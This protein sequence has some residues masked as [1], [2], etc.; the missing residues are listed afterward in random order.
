[1]AGI[2]L[3]DKPLAKRAGDVETAYPI[4]SM[5]AICSFVVGGAGLF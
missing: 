2:R 5:F 1:M 3:W 4:C